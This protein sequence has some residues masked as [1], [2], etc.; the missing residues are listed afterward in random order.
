[1]LKFGVSKEAVRNRL[2]LDGLDTNI[3]DIDPESAFLTPR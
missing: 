2:L 3:V 1:M